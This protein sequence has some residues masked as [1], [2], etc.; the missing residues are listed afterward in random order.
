MSLYGASNYSDLK[1]GTVID[2]I[3]KRTIKDI[4]P[5]FEKRREQLK[6]VQAAAMDMSAGFANVITKYAPQADICFDPFHVTQIVTK[7]LDTV[8]KQEQ[9]ALPEELRKEFF[10]SRYLFLTNKENV[11]EHRSEHFEDLKGLAVRTSRG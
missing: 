9:D 6:N 5:W 2:T 7:A 11:P 4:S 8:R 3:D 1:A 10:R